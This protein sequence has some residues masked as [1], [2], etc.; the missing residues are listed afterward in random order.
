[1]EM[2][3]TPRPG[4]SDRFLA[5][6]GL[7]A[8]GAF[9]VSGLA[10]LLSG[11]GTAMVD[12]IQLSPAAPSVTAGQTVQFTAMGIYGHGSDH[13]ST[14]QD[15]TSLVTWTSSSPS[16]VSVSPTG[17]ATGVAAGSATITAAMKG[18]TGLVAG[19]ATVTVTSGTSGGGGSPTSGSLLSLTVIPNAITV[20]NLQDTGQF[21]AI[22]TFSAPPLV[23]DLTNSVT[24][25]SSFPSVFPVNSNGTGPN[26]GTPAG[27]VTAY[28]SG[29]ATITAEAKDS[30]TGS[31]QTATA[32]FACP[33]LMPSGSTPGT[34]YPG[35]QAPALLATVTVY[36]E[37][38][39]TTGW[40]VTAPS[41]TGTLNVLH[42]GPGSVAAGLGPSVC[43]ATY[44]IGTPI[45]LTAPAES[46]VQFGGWS[47]SCTAINPN[48]STA[49]GPNQCSF[50][51]NSTNTNI[52]VGAIFN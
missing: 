16:V 34:C 44:P 31:L 45:T 25:I 29:N 52:S 33:L 48:P 10:L 6:F 20:G 46:G 50:T 7:P 43:V 21:L 5:R 22:G 8:G 11:C 26:P 40:L 47:S 3:G 1:M 36:N 15:V 9:L 32:T 37:G 30:G 42:C 18:F 28:G 51:I 2:M 13:P 39:N 49:A 19:A 38:L 12:T 27:I 41:A 24:W 14:T 23:R 4:F 17:L 35:S